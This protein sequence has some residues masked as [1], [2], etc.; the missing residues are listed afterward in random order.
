MHAG[1]L[2]PDPETAIRASSR[3]FVR[4]LAFTATEADLLELCGKHGDVTSVHLV[5]DRCGSILMLK[6]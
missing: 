5:I 2:A 3:L 6:L 1:L 4:N